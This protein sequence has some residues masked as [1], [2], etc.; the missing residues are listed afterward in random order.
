MIFVEIRRF[1]LVFSV[2]ESHRVTGY[3][4]FVDLENL[5]R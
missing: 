2:H 5:E 3:F 4:Y 1:K